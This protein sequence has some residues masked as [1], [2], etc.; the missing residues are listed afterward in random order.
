MKNIITSVLTGLLLSGMVMLQAQSETTEKVYKGLFGDY[1]YKQFNAW[2]DS[3]KCKE[4]ELIRDVASMQNGRP[5]S[6]DEKIITKKMKIFPIRVHAVSSS[7]VVTDF[8]GFLRIM[9]GGALIYLV[10]DRSDL[11]KLKE[12]DPYTDIICASPKRSIKG[13]A[14]Q[15]RYLVEMI[16]DDLDDDVAQYLK[17]NS[18]VMLKALAK[19]IDMCGEPVTVP[20]VR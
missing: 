8:N 15:T 3:V 4:R 7:N 10:T 17:R 6:E 1:T 13:N 12:T 14:T 9:E 2:T 20:A 19:D 11:I 18:L 16:E 5:V